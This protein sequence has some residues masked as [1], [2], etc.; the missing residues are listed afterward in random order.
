[1]KNKN[2]PNYLTI[3][4]VI[5]IPFFVVAVLLIPTWDFM[6]YVALGI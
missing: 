6:K 2:I 3:L 4:R 1:M 5:L